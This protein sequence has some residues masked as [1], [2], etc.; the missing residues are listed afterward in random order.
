MHSA[1]ES[2]IASYQPASTIDR[3][4]A[5]KEVIQEV[6]LCGLSRGGFFDRAAFYG[7]TALRI[8]YGLDRFSEDLDFSLF[9]PDADFDLSRYF[10]AVELE[11]RSFGLNIAIAM[12]EKRRAS[13]I[14]SAFLKG[15]T[16]EHLLYFY[17]EEGTLAGIPSDEKLKIKFEV[18]ANPPAKARFRRTFR[19][20]PSPYEICL[21]DE[22]SLFAG[23]IHAVLCRSWKNRVKGRD[24]YDYLFYL[25]RGASVNME[26]LEAR[27]VQ[28]GFLEERERLD[29]AKVRKLLGERFS[30]IDFRDARRDVEPF[31]ADHRPLDLWSRDFFIAVTE[32]LKGA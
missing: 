9:D 29:I 4:N 19:L 14:Q 26:H 11:A 8:F 21:Y 27:L 25:G 31:V 3:K 32:G 15:N 1:I 12:R 10:E 30:H 22:P 20:A 5:A 28:T 17:P 6:V 7:G 18:D 13:D 2:M 23:K 24:L 16:R